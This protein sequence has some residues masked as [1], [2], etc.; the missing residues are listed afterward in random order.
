GWSSTLPPYPAGE[1][2]RSFARLHGIDQARQTVA[3]LDRLVIL[4]AQLRCRVERDP[5]R[6][7]GAQKAA[8][9]FE[10]ARGLSDVRRIERGVEHLGVREVGRHIDR[11]DGDHADA[12]VTQLALQQPGEL[13]LDQVA[14][15]LSATRISSSGP[16]HRL[17]ATS[18]TSNTSNWSF[19]LRSLKFLSDM[20]HS[21]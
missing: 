10:A 4:E 13:P 3:A 20:P 9:A 11:G 15:L 14:E 18:S 21:K 8:R 5:P 12:R 17:L 1:R 16:L 6:E 19:S 2:R 7:L